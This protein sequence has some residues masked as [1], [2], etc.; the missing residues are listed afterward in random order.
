MGEMLVMSEHDECGTESCTEEPY[1]TARYCI[2]HLPPL[3]KEQIDNN[4]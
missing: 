1:K 3:D 2:V 4:D